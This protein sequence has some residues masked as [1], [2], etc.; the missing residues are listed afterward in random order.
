MNKTEMKVYEREVKKKFSD[1]RIV[2]R[3]NLYKL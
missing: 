3:V 1:F 2:R